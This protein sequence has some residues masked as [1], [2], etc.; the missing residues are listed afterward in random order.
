MAKFNV[1]RKRIG[2]LKKI[3]EFQFKKTVSMIIKGMSNFSFKVKTDNEFKDIL[4]YDGSANSNSQN[5]PTS[6]DK[7]RLDSASRE[8]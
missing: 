7:S 8:T 3:N 4:S 6:Y 2:I 5:I 1:K